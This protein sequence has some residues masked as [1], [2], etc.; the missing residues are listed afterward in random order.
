MSP[1]P[2][3][4]ILR[5]LLGTETRGE[6]TLAVRE[7][8]AACALFDLSAST[9][10]VALAR[11]VAAGLLV[12]PHRG[13]YALGPQARALADAV[14]RWRRIADHLV[15]WNGDW[16]AV[17]V[18]ASGRSDRPALRARERAFDLLG[19]AE[20]ERGLHLRPDNLAGGV[21]ALRQRLQAL[22]PAGTDTG[23]VFTLRGL[24]DH[25]VARARGLWDGDA[26]N[27]GY[28][29]T[30]ARLSAWIEGCTP[31]DA[32]GRG[33]PGLRAGPPRHPA[34]GVRPAAAGAAGGRAT[35]ARGSSTPSPA[36]TT[37]AR[38]SGS[39]SWPCRALAAIHRPRRPPHE[40]HRRQPRCTAATW[41]TRTSR[42]T[43]AASWSTST[44]TG[45]TPRWWP[46]CSAK[47]RP[48]PTRR[49]ATSAAWRGRPT[50]WSWARWPTAT[51]P[52]WTRTTASAAAWTW[53]ASTPRTT[54]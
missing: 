3:S 48:G 10:R 27:A 32:A 23:T 42:S 25:D 31:A 36:T 5:L 7:L 50:T 26:L 11:A 2:R 16:I 12:T 41:P 39:T 17:H 22:V 28:R 43:W 53:C 30:T 4:L 14:H 38:R 47:A 35:R 51:R 20:F 1:L 49:C 9:V 13:V 37:R 21:A 46:P 6:G 45:R 33:A 8:L 34:A 15:D 24:A 44:C 52:S 29:D 19:L 18:G 40:R 54:S